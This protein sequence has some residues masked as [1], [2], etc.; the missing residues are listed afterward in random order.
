MRQKGAAVRQFSTPNVSWEDLFDLWDVLSYEKGLSTSFKEI[1]VLGSVAVEGIVPCEGFDWLSMEALEKPIKPKKRTISY[2]FGKYLAHIA[3]APKASLYTLKKLIENNLNEKAFVAI[4]LVAT[5]KQFLGR[6]PDH[7]R[8]WNYCFLE[9]VE[10]SYISWKGC[11]NDLFDWGH[12][13]KWLFPEGFYSDEVVDETTELNASIF[14]EMALC[15]LAYYYDAY[16]PCYYLRT[17]IDDFSRFGELM[18]DVGIRVVF[19]DEVG[20]SGLNG[21]TGSA[22][23]RNKLIEGEI[24][25]C[26]KS[27]RHREG[28]MVDR[29]SLAYERSQRA[30]DACLQHYGCRCAICGMDF[31]EKF[32]EEFAGVIEVHHLEPLGL[33]KEEH[34]IDP[35]EDLVPLCPNCHKMAHRKPGKPYTLEQL[36]VIRARDSLS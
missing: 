17:G 26:D 15:N 23:N 29:V 7:W 11:S 14:T 28:R 32:G 33:L 2:S 16:R 13:S 30:R 35:I 1:V 9:E 4:A 20:C 5:S 8:G 25:N 12:S 31:G 24:K 34:E 10:K 19:Q 22:K 36:K 27:A 6:L 3:H 21:K 18:A